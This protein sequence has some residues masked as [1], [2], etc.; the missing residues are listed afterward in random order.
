LVEV[1]RR[2]QRAPLMVGI[3]KSALIQQRIEHI[4]SEA[5]QKNLGVSVR[6][7][8]LAALAVFALTVASAKAVLAPVPV[9]VR[10][11]TAVRPK[12]AEPSP[13]QHATISAP[14]LTVHAHEVQRGSVTPGAA[15]EREERSYNPRALLDPTYPPSATYVPASTIVHDGREFYV[16]SN[17][18]P[19]ADVTISY[20]LERHVHRANCRGDSPCGN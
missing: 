12:Q 6:I 15:S 9:K 3:A 4:L 17:E 11:Q 8:S 13:H 16:R 2:A 18:K 5:P 20:A 1:S 10:P 14:A 19:V 7:S